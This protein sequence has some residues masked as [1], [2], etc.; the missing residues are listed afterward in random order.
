[1]YNKHHHLH[2][3]VLQLTSSS[4]ATSTT[5]L[6]S[7]SSNNGDI[8][9]RILCLHGK[10]GNGEQFINKSLQPLRSMIDK[11]CKDNNISFHWTA[12]T[13]PYQISP[14]TNKED[15]D[16]GYAWWTMP[17]GV[18]S[19]NAKEYIGFDTTE[20]M[21]MNKLHKSDIILTHSQGAI[22]TAALLSKHDT[23]WNTTLDGSPMGYILNGVAWPNPFSK[24]LNSLDQEINNSV[25]L[26]RMLFVMGKEDNINPIESAM[27]VHDVY[28]EGNFDVSIV[29]HNRGHSVPLGRDDDSVRAL[30]EI[31]DWII[32]IA[33]RKAEILT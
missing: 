29:N 2:R 7:N 24:A 23:L 22:L 28:K 8:D 18:R 30:E 19:Y 5:S 10:G 13:A 32:D 9:I 25:S 21:V 15:D 26:P 11:R 3:R 20:D 14:P 16:G 27:Q 17:P 12:I 4:M 31:C 6:N 1:M 33:K